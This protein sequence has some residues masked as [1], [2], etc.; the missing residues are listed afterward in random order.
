MIGRP[1]HVYVYF[2]LFVFLVTSLIRR[3]LIPIAACTP[4]TYSHLF[5]LFYFHSCLLRSTLCA[6]SFSSGRNDDDICRLGPTL[7]PFYARFYSFGRTIR[8]LKRG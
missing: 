7:R 8:S 5:Y 1:R 3:S 6:L 2:R 4:N